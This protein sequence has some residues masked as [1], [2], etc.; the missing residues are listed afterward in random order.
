MDAIN[1]ALPGERARILAASGSKKKGATLLL[2]ATA[3]GVITDPRAT[4]VEVVDGL[5]FEFLAGDF[6]QNNP[7]ILPAFTRHARE[8]ASATGNRFLVDAY[9]G[10]G[11]FAL[12]AASAFEAVDGVEICESAVRQATANA[13]AN[14][15]A[16]ARFLA[17]HAAAIFGDIS[18]PAGRTTVLIDPPR[19]GADEA[20]LSQLFAFRPSRVVYVSCNPA[21]QM[22]DLKAFLGAGY[23][24]GKVQPFDLF[25]QTKHLECVMTLDDG[26]SGSE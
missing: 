14:G 12:T 19:A 2:R 21:T 16:N 26:Q 4:A 10:S 13:R 5:R 25:P 15:I 22:R 6:F 17:G 9:C 7:F 24:L 3:D 1:A 20:F 18:R 11:L 8:E 23:R